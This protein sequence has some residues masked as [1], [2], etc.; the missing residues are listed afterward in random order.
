MRLNQRGSLFTGLLGNKSGRI[1][2]RRA[3]FYVLFMLSICAGMVM[4]TRDYAFLRVGVEVHSAS[5]FFL[6]ILPWLVFGA[7]RRFPRSLEGPFLTT[8]IA[9]GCLICGKVFL[10]ANAAAT[11]V[12]QMKKLRTLA[13]ATIMY[14]SDHSEKLPPANVWMDSIANRVTEED[15]SF[16][17]NMIPAQD[18]YHV[19]MNS[20]L[21]QKSVE[22]LESPDD[23]ILYF[24]SFKSKRNANDPLHSV[25]DFRRGVNVLG[26]V[27]FISE[28]SSSK[29]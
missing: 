20:N 1:R 18:G 8:L 10:S 29:P 19:A 11:R 12:V 27:K 15:L 22:N 6:A 28:P 2:I 3:T 25:T 17:K 16:G 24:L 23:S 21:S 14:A 26:D 9:F 4:I 7:S 13:Q 5:I